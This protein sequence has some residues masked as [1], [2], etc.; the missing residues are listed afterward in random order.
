MIHPGKRSKRPTATPTTPAATSSA[1]S[2]S[3]KGTF[4]PTIC[5]PD[6]DPTGAP[7]SAQKII[8]TVIIVRISR[9]N[10]NTV[11]S[12][13]SAPASSPSC[14]DSTNPPGIAPNKASTLLSPPRR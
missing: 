2:C 4:A 12:R 5:A 10:C 9:R 3:P 1:T 11:S 14:T 7:V 13:T 6:A 8:G